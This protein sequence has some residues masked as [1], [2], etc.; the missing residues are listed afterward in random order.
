MELALRTPF[1]NE[2]EPTI[3]LDDH[4]RADSDHF[5]RIP[6]GRPPRLTFFR[7]KLRASRIALPIVPRA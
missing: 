4:D 3:S 2:S 1:W 5:S 7:D 6:D